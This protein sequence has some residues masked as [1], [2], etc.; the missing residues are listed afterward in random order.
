[1]LKKYNFE[2]ITIGIFIMSSITPNFDQR[3]RPFSSSS[4]SHASETD[5][6]LN[7]DIVAILTEKTPNEKLSHEDISIKIKDLNEKLSL[8][9]EVESEKNKIKL[10]AARSGLIHDEVAYSFKLV[11]KEELEESVQDLKKQEIENLIDRLKSNVSHIEN[12]DN[13]YFYAKLNNISDVNEKLNKFL[14]FYIEKHQ[15]SPNFNPITM[16]QEISDNL[17]FLSG[18][19][20][21]SVALTIKLIQLNL[22]KTIST[23]INNRSVSVDFALKAILNS[24]V[25]NADNDSLKILSE[26]IQ[27]TSSKNRMFVTNFGIT[28]LVD[29][30]EFV[31]KLLPVIGRLDSVEQRIEIAQEISKHYPYCS[32]SGILSLFTDEEIVNHQ[33]EITSLLQQGLERSSN[34]EQK[35]YLEKIGMYIKDIRERQDPSKSKHEKDS[36][37]YRCLGSISY[38]D[39]RLEWVFKK[40]DELEY[41]FKRPKSEL[42]TK[43]VLKNDNRRVR[44]D[45]PAESNTSFQNNNDKLNV[46]GFKDE[47]GASGTFVTLPDPNNFLEHKEQTLKLLPDKVD[48]DRL[49]V[50]K[51]GILSGI[52]QPDEFNRMMKEH[53]VVISDKAGFDHDAIFHLYPTIDLL[54]STEP[55]KFLKSMENA[56]TAYTKYESLLANEQKTTERNSENELKLNVLLLASQFFLDIFTTVNDLNARE[57]FTENLNSGMFFQQVFGVEKFWWAY[58]KQYGSFDENAVSRQSIIDFLN[59]IMKNTNHPDH[60]L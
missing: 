36:P 19:F 45:F 9:K 53:H 12:E 34:A 21:P 30:T 38:D 52:V 58:E 18:N 11:T 10:L 1:M 39:G 46:L 6:S 22:N 15:G 25:W 17:T 16:D 4:Q 26:N 28:Q 33:N 43:D 59:E 54:L 35:S 23:I 20:N 51:V 40:N 31:T 57:Q 5:R 48:R 27:N 41:S 44:E 37:A 3:N 8:C 60:T 47:T 14:L 55:E 29:V 32:A 56:I 49:S 2:Y 24:N 13:S 42:T 7:P 50:L